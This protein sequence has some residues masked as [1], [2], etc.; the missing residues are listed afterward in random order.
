MLGIG[1]DSLIRVAPVV[2]RGDNPLFENGDET[3]DNQI[4]NLYI[5]VSSI[6]PLS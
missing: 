4:I 3:T 5:L 6:S 2:S 1:Y